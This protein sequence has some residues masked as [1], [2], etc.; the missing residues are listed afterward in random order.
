MLEIVVC[1]LD[2]R[3]LVEDLTQILFDA[4]RER[5]TLNDIEIPFTARIERHGI[6]LEFEFKATKCAVIGRNAWRTFCCGPRSV[7]VLEMVL[8]TLQ[9]PWKIGH[10]K[11]TELRDQPSHGDFEMTFGHGW[12]QFMRAEAPC[13]FFL[14]RPPPVENLSRSGSCPS[15]RIL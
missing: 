8:F 12:A 6:A 13:P 3:V 11:K 14:A 2:N 4:V 5:P 10:V 15:P 1:S 7:C 9:Q